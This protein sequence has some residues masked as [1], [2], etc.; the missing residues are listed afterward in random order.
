MDMCTSIVEIAPASG[1]AR[2][3]EGDWFALTQSVVAYDHARHALLEDAITLDFVNHALPPG[4]RAAVELTL[5][6]A[7]A[8]NEALARAI[9]AAEAEEAQRGL[10]RQEPPLSAPAAGL[11]SRLAA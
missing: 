4:A 11:A 10:G 1:M 3:G 8:L 7:K 5:E 9:A 2:G 6:A